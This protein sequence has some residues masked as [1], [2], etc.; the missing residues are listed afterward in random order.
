MDPVNGAP[1]TERTE[2]RI[3]FDREHLY[4]GII[5]YDSDP[6]GILGKQMLRD[7]DLGSDDRFMWSID[8]YLNERTGYYFETNPLG[9]MG[10]GLL[11]QGDSGPAAAGGTVDRQWDGI[12]IVRVNRSQIGWT[13]EVE[14]P[15]RTLNF[16]PHSSVWGINFQRTLRR[17]NEESIWSGYARNQG[18]L[19]MTNAGRLTGLTEISQ[20]AGLDIK[21]HAVASV[22][23]APG[24]GRPAA[25]GEGDA[26]VDIFYSLTPALRA[27]VTV[28]TDFAE[29][30]VDQRL[31][32]LTRFPLFFPEKREFFLEGSGFFDFAREPANQVE[33]FFSRRIGL[34]A[35]G[36][37]Q[38]IDVGFKMTGQLGG[39]DVGLLQVRTGHDDTAVGEDFTVVRVRKPMLTQS[40]VGGLYTRRA[41]RADEIDVLSTVGVDFN[42]GTSTFRRNQNLELSGFWLWTT[43]PLGT[44]Q[45]QSYGVRLN[46]P[47]DVW[48]GRISWRTVEPYYD[49]AVGFNQRSGYRRLFP[50]LRFSPR[51]L[52]HRYIRRFAWEGQL[53]W[54][55]DM[56][57]QLLLRRLNLIVLQMSMHAGDQLQVQVMPQR[58][59]LDTPFAIHEGIVLPVGEYTFTRHRVQA[60]TASQRILAAG[61]EY[62]N[63][64]FYSGDR[65]E[66][67]VALTAR[68]FAGIL[69]SIETEWN[70][71]RLVEGAFSTRVF[72]SVANVQFS[73][74]VSIGSNL[75]YDSESGI[76]GWQARFRW[77]LRP[78]NDIYVV[79]THN[80]QEFEAGPFRTFDHRAASKVVY[81]QRF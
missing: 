57:N 51:P 10:D 16:D 75:Q 77:I 70:R 30:E 41:A 12:W 5:C 35:N 81:T 64:G 47:N 24:R 78:G 34:D 50:V 56:Q 4:L 68:P 9:L 43:N 76:L 6:A 44:G 15:F 21:P 22:T 28:N 49:P 19:R 8:T 60:T 61:V 52:T 3:A 80:W 11:A 7:A 2:V 59:F 17:K 39:Q 58:E 72:R 32:N 14:L 67:V 20:G 40:Y 62:E 18:L 73:P 23:A 27:N 54:L 71:V 46:Y 45:N 42:F 38:T 13:A 36:N 53:E 1:S 65:R 29:T 26:G 37:P 33:P 69:T 63:G 79:Y 66:V 25:V 31:I 48:S 74:W 55:T